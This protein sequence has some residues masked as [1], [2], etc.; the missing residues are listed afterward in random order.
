MGT[1]ALEDPAQTAPA[2]ALLRHEKRA[3]RGLWVVDIV[4][5]TICLTF[6]MLAP[7]GQWKNQVMGVELAAWNG[8]PGG[9][10]VVGSL[11]S[12]S[13]RRHEFVGHPGM[14]MQLA[15]GAAAQV[16]YRVYRI[17][18]GRENLYAFWARHFRELFILGSVVI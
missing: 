5:L 12:F 9:G 2:D 14:P 11:Y 15:I 7:G 10:Y 3:R 13:T 6:A 8:D 17:G 16:I 4:F 1:A 18:G